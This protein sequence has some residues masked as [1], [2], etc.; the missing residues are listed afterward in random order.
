MT[1]D[2]D[3]FGGCMQGRDRLIMPDAM[4]Q[5]NPSYAGRAGVNRPTLTFRAVFRLSS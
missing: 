3:F 2:V 4:L 5:T 1:F